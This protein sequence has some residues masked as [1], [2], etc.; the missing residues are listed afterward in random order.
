MTRGREEHVDHEVPELVEEEYDGVVPLLLADDIGS[1]FL[2]PGRGF[3]PGEAA[4]GGRAQPARDLLRLQGVPAV[5]CIS[6]IS[7][8]KF[9]PPRFW[10]L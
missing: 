10:V 7:T 5:S 8:A 3:L 2:Q 9:P 1:V 4:T 6:C